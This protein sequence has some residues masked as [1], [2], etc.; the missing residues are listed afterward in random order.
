M[1]RPRITTRGGRGIE[2]VQSQRSKVQS[3]TYR[4]QTGSPE[5]VLALHRLAGGKRPDRTRPAELEALYLAEE[6][7]PGYDQPRPDRCGSPRDRRRDGRGTQRVG[8][9]R[10]AQLDINRN[11]RGSVQHFVSSLTCC[12]P[13]TRP[14]PAEENAGGG[15]PSPPRGRGQQKSNQLFPLPHGGEGNKN[16]TNSSLSLM[17]TRAIKIESILRSPSWGRGQQKSNQ[18]SPLPLGG[19]GPGVRRLLERR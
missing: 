5:P 7:P 16:R 11:V 10:P 18:V 13:L 12:D 19:E 8:A 15:P 6:L 4:P 9:R 3:L 1:G 14:A 17:G 2:E